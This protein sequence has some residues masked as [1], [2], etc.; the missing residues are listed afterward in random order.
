MAEF[1]GDETVY[2][3]YSGS[4][5][6]ACFVA[7]SV[8]KVIGLE[9]IPEAIEDAKVNAMLNDIRNG[10]FFAGDI[11]D[12]LTDEFAKKNGKPDVIITDPP[13]AGM[14][15]DAWARGAPPARANSVVGLRLLVQA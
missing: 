7:G 12:L 9:Y 1:K 15:K 6:I 4:G 11:K 10:S 13:R 14:H 3:L 2:D 8:K 5:T